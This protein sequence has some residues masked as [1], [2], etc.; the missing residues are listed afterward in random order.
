[1]RARLPALVAIVV[2]LAAPAPAPAQIRASEFASVSQVIDGTRIAMEYSRPRVRGR[3][4]LWGKV[5]HWGAVWTPGANWATT[6]DLGK[7]VKL[8]GQ[9]VPKGKY[10]VWFT[11]RESGDWTLV[12]DSTA[13]RFHMRPPDTT[14][15]RFRIPVR[16]TEGP[17][18]DVLTWSFPDLRVNGGTL[19]WQWERKRVA[20]DVEVEPSLVVTMPEAEARPYL[21]RWEMT[22]MSGR[23]SGKVKGAVVTYYEKGTLKANF[24]PRDSYMKDF[25]LIRTRGEY[26]V[27]GLY[28]E[29]GQLY[30]VLRPD[31]VFGFTRVDGAPRSFEMRGEDDE[32][33]AIGRKK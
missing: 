18:T 3:S 26:F 29:K 6:L 33:Y 31:L 30:E 21:G 19:L 23:D 1:M 27:P 9:P 14:K 24:E 11:L 22:Q 2:A 13:R 12:L 25:A 20:I 32:L 17:F 5:E 28:D 10:S 4:P 7:D 16:A 8:N 15:A